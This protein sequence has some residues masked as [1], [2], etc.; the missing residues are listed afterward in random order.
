[1]KTLVK[2]SLQEFPPRLTTQLQQAIVKAKTNASGPLYAAFD[3]DGT[4]W[5]LDMGESFFDYQLKNCGLA[6]L[7]DDPWKYYLDLK[8]KGDYEK[9]YLW[10]AQ[11]NQGIPLTQVRAWAQAFFAGLEDFPLFQSQRHLLDFLRDQGFTIYIVTA[12]VKWSVEPAAAA[13]GIPESQVLGVTTQ[14]R[15]LAQQG[16]QV[17]DLQAGPITYRQG[18][19][20]ALL[21][22]TH[23]VAPL[24]AAGNTTGDLPLLQSSTGCC[25]A[26]GSQPPG[27]DLYASEHELQ[28]FAHKHGWFTHNFY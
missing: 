24:F 10:L 21:A 4:L 14:L 9:A 28:T 26:V 3:A 23:G 6:N 8:A 20:E 18:K 17:S 2:T 11:I 5:N 15:P 13:L 16:W 19:V 22:A 25:L 1:M 27:S 7:P 12:S